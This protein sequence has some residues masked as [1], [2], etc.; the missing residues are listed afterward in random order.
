MARHRLAVAHVNRSPVQHEWL[1]AVP[2]FLATKFFGLC[3]LR[4]VHLGLYLG[5]VALALTLARRATN[6]VA[7]ITAVLIG[8]SGALG[9]D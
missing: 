7:L 1:F 8:F 4:V 9:G 3:A 2:M 6:S 5:V